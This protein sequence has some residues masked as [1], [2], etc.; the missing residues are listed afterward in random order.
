MT[1]RELDQE[2]SGFTVEIE[3]S[4]ESGRG[5]AEGSRHFVVVQTDSTGNTVVRVDVPQT[6]MVAGGY[7]HSYDN[8][9]FT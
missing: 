3:E 7:N 6:F 2:R 8:L 5:V 1:I 9:K 4:D